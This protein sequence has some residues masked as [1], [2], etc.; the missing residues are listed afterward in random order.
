MNSKL[1][2]HNAT[3]AETKLPLDIF[4]EDGFVA[5]AMSWSSKTSL[6]IA[7]LDGVGPLTQEHWS[8]IYYLRDHYMKNGAL[9]VESHVC[10]VNHLSRDAIK[11]LFGRFREAWRI[12]GLPNPGEEAKTYMN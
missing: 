2:E 10:W 11:T 5:D 8:I 6:F 4:D 7:E 1:P 9:P 3:P 12:A